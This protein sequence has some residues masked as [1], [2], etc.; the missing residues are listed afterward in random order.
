MDILIK[1]GVLIISLLA[2]GALAALLAAIIR[3]VY[4]SGIFNVG[5][6]NKSINR[7]FTKAFFVQDALTQKDEVS[8]KSTAW[9]AVISF[10]IMLSMGLVVFLYLV[11]QMGINS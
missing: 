11:P 4:R 8:T 2:I 6:T 5:A 1:I 7:N 9:R 10:I 3:L